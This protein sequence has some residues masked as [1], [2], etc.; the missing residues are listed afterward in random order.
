MPRKSYKEKRD[1]GLCPFCGKPNNNTRYALCLDCRRKR[2]QQS[3]DNRQYFIKS[4]LCTVCGKPKDD[5]KR[6]LC[7]TC[8]EKRRYYARKRTDSKKIIAM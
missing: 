1:E 8:R 3:Y 2:S 5:P 4:G 7:A 6:R